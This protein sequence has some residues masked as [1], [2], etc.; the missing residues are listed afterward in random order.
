MQIVSVKT[1]LL[2]IAI[3]SVEVVG[4]YTKPQPLDENHPKWKARPCLTFKDD[5]VLLEGLNQAKVLTNTVEI[6]NGLP[7]TIKLPEL[8]KEI[9]KIANRIIL[10][11]HVFDGEQVKLP[12]IVDPLRPAFKFRRSYGISEQRVK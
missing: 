7:E 1:F 6:Q 9:N 4:M 12:R 3:V 8:S 10:A 11:S 2:I 5:N